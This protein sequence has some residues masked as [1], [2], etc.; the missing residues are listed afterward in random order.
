MSV[1][2]RKIGFPKENCP[3]FTTLRCSPM[4]DGRRPQNRTHLLGRLHRFSSI[5]RWF[6][7]RSADPVLD[8]DLGAQGDSF[9]HV[10]ETDEASR[11]VFCSTQ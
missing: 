4:G 5:R 8:R 10:I 2:N 3:A 9:K 6:E 7:S 1:T 11:F